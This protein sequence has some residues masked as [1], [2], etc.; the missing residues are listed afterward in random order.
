MRN[1]NSSGDIVKTTATVARSS[2]DFVKIGEVF[3]FAVDDADVGGWLVIK[4]QGVFEAPLAA[5][6]VFGDPVY[7]TAT[8]FGADDSATSTYRVGVC[9]GPGLVKLG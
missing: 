4:T 3:G 2:G 9:V 1:Y 5:G 6:I 7:R 8:G